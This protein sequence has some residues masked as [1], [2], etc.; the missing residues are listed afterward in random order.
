MRRFRLLCSLAPQFLQRRGRVLEIGCGLG[1]FLRLMRGLGWQV[2]GIEPDREYAESGAKVYQFPITAGIFEEHNS[3]PGTYDAVAAFHV[4]EHIASPRNFLAQIEA[5]LQKGGIVLLEVPSL[6]RPYGGDLKRFFWSA[7]LHSFSEAT[8][9]GLLRDVGL[10]PL[11]AG[12]HS[13]FLWM[14]AIKTGIRSPIQLPL[15]PPSVVK[16]RILHQHRQF[17]LRQGNS[18]IGAFARSQRTAE[19]ALA[20]YRDDPAEF[21]AG[22]HRRTA[23]TRIRLEHVPTI[24][25]AARRIRGPYLAH[26]GI[27]EA[28]N[29]GDTVLFW[30][31]RELFDRVTGRKHWLRESV[32]DKVDSDTV[33]RI[34][35]EAGGVIVGGGGLLLRDTRPNPNSGWQWNCSAELIARLDVPLTIFAIGYNRF[36]DQAEFEDVFRENIRIL[37]EQS[38]FFGLRN[39]GSIQAVAEYL[40]VSLQDR[41]SFQPCPTTVIGRFAPEFCRPHSLP[42]PKRLAL[43]CAFDR[44]WLRFAGSEAPIL[45]Q[46]C[47]AMKWATEHGWELHLSV[48][49]RGDDTVL[50]YLLREE[51]PFTEH[52]LYG[53]PVSK[54]LEF[55]RHMP[56]TIGMR[57]HSQMIPFGL[58]NA[59]LSLASHDKLLYFL[60]DIGHSE[61]GIDVQ[62]S[63]LGEKIIAHIDTC[64]QNWKDLYAQVEA[65]QEG[66]WRQTLMNVEMIEPYLGN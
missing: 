49:A 31:V 32:W 1:S 20:L 37:V 17:Q 5:Q 15:Q 57:G 38:S 2:V 55:Y 63:D 9:G 60:D 51:V 45:T 13:D 18:L 54:V 8:L 22:L 36:R 65:A 41:L 61:W 43:N 29:A 4:V 25:R 44:H 48:H 11:H 35:K 27:H 34:N 58:G 59:I 26:Y 3:S 21:S 39:T 30:A 52:Q 14:L 47:K 56:L 53:H 42:P 7:H 66:L 64:E 50:P 33:N 40:P 12:Y 16:S 6:N 10:L 28:G 24:R 23:R 46:I 62:D 19:R